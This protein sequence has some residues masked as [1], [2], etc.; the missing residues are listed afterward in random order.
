MR[1]TNTL[2]E[3]K[4]DGYREKMYDRYYNDRKTELKALEVRNQ[5]SLGIDERPRPILASAVVHVKMP[6]CTFLWPRHV[7]FHAITAIENMTVKTKADR[8]LQARC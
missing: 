1:I 5:K 7:T 2:L 4:Y 6:G 3:S 8:E